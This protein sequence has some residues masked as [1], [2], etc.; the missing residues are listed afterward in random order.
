MSKVIDL[1]QRRRARIKKRLGRRRNKHVELNELGR[2]FRVRLSPLMLDLYRESQAIG[3]TKF[4][5]EGT[6]LHELIDLVTKLIVW[7]MEEKADDE[8]IAF[9]AMR[10]RKM[11]DLQAEGKLPS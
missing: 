6:V 9:I 1:E 7:L 10:L 8:M 5:C 11:R 3:A 2:T 4:E